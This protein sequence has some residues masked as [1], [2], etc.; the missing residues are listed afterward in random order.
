LVVR[1]HAGMTLQRDVAFAGFGGK[2]AAI[3]IKG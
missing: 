3:K 1:S 2:L